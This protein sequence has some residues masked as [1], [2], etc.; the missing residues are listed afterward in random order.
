MSKAFKI[1]EVRKNIFLFAF[2]N[3]YDL[4]MHFLRYQEYYESPNKKFRGKAFS[5]LNFMKWYSNSS[6]P[7]IEGAFTYPVDWDGFN[8]PSYVI[9]NV[10]E[11]GIPDKNAYDK[12]IWKAYKHCRKKANDDK[13]YI[14]GVSYEGKSLSDALDHEIAHGLFYTCD[15]YKV[16]MNKLVLAMNPFLREAFEAWLKKKGYA[17]QVYTDETQAYMATSEDFG[18]NKSFTPE[19]AISL[20]EAAKDFKWVFSQYKNKE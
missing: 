1:K 18:N 10:R 13:F 16:A 12:A 8:L 17:K 15:E 14:I 20:N 19:I 11:L 5:I 7:K 3:Q 2:K 4:C 9:E 6:F